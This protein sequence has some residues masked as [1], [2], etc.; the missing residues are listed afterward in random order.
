M[1][2]NKLTCVNKMIDV[3]KVGGGEQ[4]IEAVHS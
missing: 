2:V 4:E 1:C 3:N